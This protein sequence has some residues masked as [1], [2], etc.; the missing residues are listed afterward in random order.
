MSKKIYFERHVFRDQCVSE[1]I[2]NNTYGFSSIKSS[3][4]EI[5]GTKDETGKFKIWKIYFWA[6]KLY[7]I[8]TFKINF[9][10]IKDIKKVG[11]LTYDTIFGIRL[12]KVFNIEIFLFRKFQKANQIGDLVTFSVQLISN[13]RPSKNIKILINS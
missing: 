3:L 4:M 1:N 10:F 12:E 11:L 7:G 8:Y 9:Y 13:R 2:L 5:W 6:L